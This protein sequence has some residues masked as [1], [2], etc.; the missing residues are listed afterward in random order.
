MWTPLPTAFSIS[1]EKIRQSQNVASAGATQDLILNMKNLSPFLH[2]FLYDLHSTVWVSHGILRKENSQRLSVYGAKHNQRKCPET[3]GLKPTRTTNPLSA[4]SSL[5]P[6]AARSR[7]NSLRK[8]APPWEEPC[9]HRGRFTAHGHREPSAS[10]GQR[11][12]AAEQSQR[13]A[14]PAGSHQRLLQPRLQSCLFLWNLIGSKALTSW[15]W[16][17]VFFFKARNLK[18]HFSFIFGLIPY[19]YIG[20]SLK[21]LLLSNRCHRISSKYFSGF[22]FVEQVLKVKFF[23]D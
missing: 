9:Q 22:L 7:T 1:L 14:L 2:F 10:Q 23:S 21:A 13:W 11:N 12:P 3:R 5:P 8:S 20:A 6:P 17:T 15:C 16:S 4:N 18:S 19:V